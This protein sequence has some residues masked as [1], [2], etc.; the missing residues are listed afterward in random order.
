MPD[1]A[2]GADTADVVIIGA[3]IVG[4]ST[5]RALLAQSPGLRVVV[6]EKEA[7]IASHQTGRNSNVV[8]SGIYYKPG[9]LKAKYAIEGGRALE[10]YCGERGLP[11]ATTGKV[12]VATRDQERPALAALAQRGRD[13]GLAVRELTA[14][15]LAEREPHVRAVASLLVPSTAVTDFLAVAHAY[16]TD[17]EAGGGKL[18]LGA[19]VSGIRT[20]AGEV[21]VTTSDGAALPA[22]ILVNCA[23]LQSDRMAV[24]AGDIPPA[25]I[26]PFR[27]EY[28]ELVPQRRELVRALVYPVPDP[29]FPF[30]GVHLTRGV[31]GGVHAGPNAVLAF[32]REGYRRWSS[33]PS[34][35]SELARFRGTWALAR[36]YWRTGMGEYG[37]SLWR[38]AFLRALQRLVPELTTDDL[39]PS[40]PGVRAQAVGRDGALLDDFL[41]SE[42]PHAVHVLNA[43]SPAATASLPIGA[44][45]ARLVLGRLS[46]HDSRYAG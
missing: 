1:S 35:L 17:V 14:A 39:V 23:G 16:R 11:F 21:I 46:A 3:G 15:E 19:A 40:A 31:D 29:R 24:L 44:H 43:P 32:R 6:V 25:R 26:L 18:R 45:I 22:R 8:H 42:G 38:P 28:Y 2:G 34:E 10:A 41:I 27:G 36:R 7:A 5:A 13:H 20:T 4:L 33:T 12:I 9:S 37:R 30:L